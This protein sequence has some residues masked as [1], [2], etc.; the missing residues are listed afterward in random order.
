MRLPPLLLAA[1]ALALAALAPQAAEAQNATNGQNQYTFYCSGCHGAVASNKDRI[2]NGAARNGGSQDIYAAMT[3][4]SA[5]MVAQIYP[6]YI[7]GN[8][9]DADLADIAAYIDSRLPAS[10]GASLDVPGSA[11]FGSHLVGTQGSGQVISVG[12]TGTGPLTIA[13]F[14]NNNPGEFVVTANTCVAGNAAFP[15]RIDVAFRPAAAGMRTGTL[16]LTSDGTG[17][18]QGIA[19]TGTGVVAGP[20]PTPPFAATVTVV[21]YFHEKFDHY[22]ITAIADEIA[23]LDNGTFAG[24]TRTGASFKSYATP[25]AGTVAVCRFFSSAF[26]P[27]SS[28]FYTASTPECTAV[29]ANPDWSFEG[30]VLNV[31]PP[32]AD[33][34]C[35]SGNVPVYRLYNDG[36]G[37]APNH[38]YTTDPAV[39]SAMQAKRWVPEGNGALG[40]TMCVPP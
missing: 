11:E 21:E 13:G 22:F 27:K 3:F 24:W 7:A 26:A 14:A 5:P 31:T 9:N 16:T 30:E 33:G 39:R 28:H 19:L 8:L 37:A 38:R 25:V 20:A 23:K 36:Q 17:S 34:S 35:P 4:I 40:V 18:P 6:L 15:C 10:T 1:P 2:Q 32:A 12:R 29:K